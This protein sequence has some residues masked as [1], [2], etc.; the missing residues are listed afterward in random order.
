MVPSRDQKYRRRK[1]KKK[2]QS[3]LYSEATTFLLNKSLSLRSKNPELAKEYFI[4]ARKMGMRGRQHIPKGYRIL[5]CKSCNY[6]IQSKTIKVRLN[7]KKKQISYNCL[8]CGEKHRFGYRIK[9]KI[10]DVNRDSKRPR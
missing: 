7:S 3:N 2:E 6:P 5:F 9:K 1:N 8:R 10:S 4:S